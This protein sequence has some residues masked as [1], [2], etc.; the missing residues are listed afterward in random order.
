MRHDRPAF[1]SF[2]KILQEDE[3]TK[4]VNTDIQNFSCQT[5]SGFIAQIITANTNT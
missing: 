3:R 2:K 5:Y 4:R 1:G